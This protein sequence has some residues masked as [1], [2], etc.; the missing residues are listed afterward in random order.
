MHCADPKNVAQACWTLMMLDTDMDLNT[1]TFDSV[2]HKPRPRMF[3]GSTSPVRAR[4]I[5]LLS[6]DGRCLQNQ[7]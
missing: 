6:R 5:L 1:P 3:A 4:F 2:Y 7:V